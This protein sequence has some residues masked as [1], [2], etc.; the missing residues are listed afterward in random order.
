MPVSGYRSSNFCL[1]T[2]C[3]VFILLPAPTSQQ[4]VCHA[5]ILSNA[6]CLP[7]PVSSTPVPQSP[8][9]ACAFAGYDEEAQYFEPGVRGAKRA[10]LESSLHALAAPHM[11]AQLAMLA[12]TALGG[13][14][15]AL[16]AA[17]V[18]GEETF[19]DA[20]ARCGH[21]AKY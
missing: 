11:R 13:F 16:P 1:Y 3:S 18:G 6:I 8:T 7:I 20:A 9:H 14:K 15:Q 12:A 2:L 19:V 10:E 4:C 17:V 21:S 5:S